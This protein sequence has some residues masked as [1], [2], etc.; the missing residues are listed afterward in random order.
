MSDQVSQVSK[1]ITCFRSLW[2]A[3]G[4]QDWIHAR[5]SERESHQGLNRNLQQTVTLTALTLAV[6]HKVEVEH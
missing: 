2:L 3:A 6:L 4:R 1:S 5:E